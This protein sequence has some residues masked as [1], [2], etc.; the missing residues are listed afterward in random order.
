MKKKLLATL[1]VLCTLLSALPMLASPA[2]AAEAET[3][4]DYD[5]LYV[6]DGLSVWL[7]A[8]DSSEANTDIDLEANT[9]KS[10]VGSAVATLAEGTLFP[11]ERRAAG[12]IGWTQKGSV[13]E[14]IQ[15]NGIFLDPS[16]IPAGDYTAEFVIATEGITADDGSRWVHKYD[17][18]KAESSDPEVQKQAGNRYGIGAGEVFAIGA[19]RTYS[20]YCMACHWRPSTG[21]ENHGIADQLSHRWYF[22]GLNYTDHYTS[23][24]NNKNSLGRYLTQEGKMRTFAP[25]DVY[26]MTMVLERPTQDSV[27]VSVTYNGENAARGSYTA[28]D[29]GGTLIAN[30]AGY[31]AGG[32]PQAN[33]VKLQFMVGMAGT[34]YSIRLYSR[35]LTDAE[36]TQNAF[37][38]VVRYHK[39]D[40]TAYNA[41]AEEA[42]ESVRKA[43]VAKGFKGT[44]ADIEASILQA[45]ADYDAEQKR[46]EEAAADRAAL[47]ESVQDRA[48]DAYDKY[49]VQKNLVIFLDG[50]VAL[51]EW[52]TNLDL[53]NGTWKSKVGDVTATITGTEYWQ[54]SYDGQGIGFRFTKDQ[55]R[56]SLVNGICPAGIE[57]DPALL[58]A[59]FTVETVAK[60]PGLTNADGSRFEDSADSPDTYGVYTSAYSTF[61]FDKLKSMT[62]LCTSHASRGTP[63]GHRWCFTEKEWKDHN[64]SAGY[65]DDITLSKVDGN[66]ILT[67]TIIRASSSDVACNVEV[68]IDLESKFSTAFT[69]VPAKDPDPEF[70]MFKGLPSTVYAIRV[71]S[72]KLT[73]A[74]QAQNHMADLYNYYGLDTEF[75]DLVLECTED[76]KTV[77]PLFNDLGFEMTKE[78]AD[79]EIKN[80]LAGAWIRSLGL[81]ARVDGT[82]ALRNVF[83][84]NVAGLNTMVENGYKIE[85]GALLN[86]GG[87][88][89]TLESKEYQ[90]VFFDDKVGV[91]SAFALS[92]PTADRVRLGLDVTFK[93]PRPID[94]I[95]GVNYKA[96]LVLID[97]DG[98]RTELY[99]DCVSKKFD[100]NVF[101]YYSYLQDV[102]GYGNTNF[103]KKVVN[104]CFRPVQ[105]EIDAEKGSDEADGVTAAVKS[106]E[107]AWELLAELLTQETPV[108]VTM[109]FAAGTYRMSDK[110]TLDGTAHN[111]KYFRLTLRGAA[112]DSS[113]ITTN[114]TFD[115]SGWKPVAGKPYYE[116]QFAKDAEGK[117]PEF[118][119]LYVNGAV[120]E[121]AHEGYN[122]TYEAEQAGGIHLMLKVKDYFAGVDKNSSNVFYKELETAG[123]YKLYLDPAV[124]EGVTEEDLKTGKLEYHMP[125][126]WY[127]RV[128]H[129][130]A[131]DRS[132]VDEN[133]NIAVF[134]RASELKN[135]SAQHTFKGHYYWLQ[136]A[137]SFVDEPGEFFYDDETGKMIYYPAEGVDM[138]SATF[139]YPTHDHMMS[140]Y[141]V[142]G[143]TV[144]SM[145]FTGND[146]LIWEDAAYM[147][148]QATSSEGDYGANTKT[149]LYFLNSKN[150]TIK[151]S[152]F[153]DLATSAVMFHGVT[154]NPH[155][156]GSRFFKIG[157][158]AL[159]FGIHNGTWDEEKTANFD[160]YVYNN[161]INDVAWMTRGSIGIYV[162]VSKNTEIAYNTIM[163]TSYTGISIGWRW[164][165]ADWE[166]GTYTQT[167]NAQLHHNYFRD[168]MTDQ[169]D[170]GGIYTLGG[171]AANDYHEYFNF[172]YENYF[173]FTDKTWDGQGMVMP[174]YHDGGSSNWNTAANVLIHHP[175]RKY[176]AAIYLQNI[177]AQYAHNIL[178]NDNEIVAALKDWYSFDN[179]IPLEYEEQEQK[180]FGADGNHRK[181]AGHGTKY[182]Y[183][184][185]VDFDRDLAQENNIVYDH[186]LDIAD[187]YVFDMI[188]GTGCEMFPADPYEMVEVMSPVYDA[189]YEKLEEDY[190]NAE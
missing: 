6:K 51:N 131:I 66:K 152:Y 31:D 184:S 85:A 36:R 137:A 132:D 100:Y 188:A 116:Y 43:I 122:R 72:K 187:T 107:R 59:N 128:L 95:L 125:I 69:V 139:E 74:E 164:N 35:A 123:V 27:N 77:Y 41:M 87:E 55:Y 190:M 64:G 29:F 140:F 169:S 146:N 45:K 186:P 53:A 162:S 119:F 160:I 177:P 180:L 81:S 124:F 52:N 56:A 102:A 86:L 101:S 165:P 39:V 182:P 172:M 136:N 57:F 134:F 168:I 127:Y 67:Y 75:L 148:G 150:V 130:D 175:F 11:W 176:H 19:F 13:S 23:I 20:Y 179:Q 34:V 174:Y 10:K 48:L 92:D 1:L 173:W 157:S 91:H 170:G 158:S 22:T 82:I 145:V 18:D 12:G 171:N 89:P 65:K 114:Q 44:K 50:F 144:D 183:Y 32:T 106:V 8:F 118:R 33:R 185:R 115:G 104:N 98:E 84:L 155:V 154:R 120:Q 79:Y 96:Y 76:P 147:G 166:Y 90:V 129:I 112:K 7:D 108:D 113:V 97:P 159:E 80:R 3:A 105:I 28:E 135:W 181:P 14:S 156:E 42:K 21:A 17:L 126:A 153:H 26:N 163:N 4:T 141:N 40:L 189:W 30:N 94:S 37:A 38:D 121:V 103:I 167:D 133:G 161:W 143:I 47:L 88:M 49:Y 25:T 109:N 99:L 68:L 9:W 142:S 138:A 78:E 151:D 24:N 117:Y 149:A 83:E 63:M 62:F 93:N 111:Q 2:A 5:A 73:A 178:V 58:P 60:I 61:S 71:Y 15:P 110:V 16:L 54:E 70:H 46:K